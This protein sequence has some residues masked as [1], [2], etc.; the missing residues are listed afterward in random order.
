MTYSEIGPFVTNIPDDKTVDL[1]YFFFLDNLMEGHI[2][3]D[4]WLCRHCC[5]LRSD[6]SD[7]SLQNCNQNSNDTFYQTETYNLLKFTN[8]VTMKSQ[9]HSWLSRLNT[10]RWLGTRFSLVGP[11]NV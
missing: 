10:S 11:T 3:A 1:L 2:A 5:V 8:T 9:T 7:N 4:D 6:H